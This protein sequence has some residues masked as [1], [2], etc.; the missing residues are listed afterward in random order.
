M[1]TI[2]FYFDFVSPY[3]YLAAHE[4]ANIAERRGCKIDYRPIDLVA[5]KLAAGNNGPATAQMPLKL[6]YAMADF[7]RWGKR[8]NLPLAFS[9][10]GAP[11]TE[12]ENKGTFY[13]IDRGQAA[14]YV[15]VMWRRTFGEG[16][17]H[18]KADVLRA[19]AA[20]MGWDA[21][22]FLAFCSSDEAAR[23]YAQSNSG[24]HAK[25]VFGAPTMIVGTE[26]WWGND[27][28]D[29]LEEYLAEKCA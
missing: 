11:V 13:A 2:E 10:E 12:V 1:T 28:L 3:S 18:G 25:G 27:R 22:E 7:T 15:N 29:F 23:R 6:Q 16:G 9:R 14:Q 26:L 19:A 5:T 4:L 21:D 24:A 17:L 8:Y 20:E